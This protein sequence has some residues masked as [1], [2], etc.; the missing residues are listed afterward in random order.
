MFDTDSRLLDFP[1]LSEVVYLNSAAEGLPPRAVRDAL[2]HYYDDHARGA[3]GRPAHFEQLTQLRSRAASLL[4]FRAD[5]VGICSCSSEAYNLLAQALDLQAGDEVIANDLD[6]P[7]GRTPWQQPSSPATLRAWRAASGELR[8]DD[9]TELLNS[10][11]RLV[12]TSLVSYHNGHRVCVPELA[13]TIRKN[14][15]AL[16]AVDVTQALG[17]IPLDLTGADIVVS[18]T[19]KWI[20]GTH[21]GGILGIREAAQEQIRCRAGG[22]HHLTHPFDG[23]P[24]AP[25]ES[26]IGAQ[27]YQCGMPNFPAIYAN[28][29]ALGY[30]EAIGIEE[31]D[32]HTRPLVQGCLDGLKSLGL[33]VITPGTADRLAGILA[34]RHPRLAEVSAALD[35]ARVVHMCSAGRIRVALH[36]YNTATDVELLLGALSNIVKS[37]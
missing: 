32:R 4:G 7:A 20:L 36:G 37:A 27:G 30:I 9:L 5:E 16:L 3:L 21:G 25:V 13:E 35:T 1:I 14:S 22:W 29:A 10:H 19:H 31:I 23:D 34:F 26:M 2:G 12:T 18:S 24:L 6:F 17:R 15:S 33:D 8:T 28:N 11:T